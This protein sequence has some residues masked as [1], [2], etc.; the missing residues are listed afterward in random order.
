MLR[1]VSLLK[2]SAA[3]GW[4]LSAEN[5]PHP[6]ARAATH[7]GLAQG[8]LIEGQDREMQIETIATVLDGIQQTRITRQHVTIADTSIAKE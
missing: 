7:S 2:S 4:R 1:L 5:P 6:R 8:R 3:Q